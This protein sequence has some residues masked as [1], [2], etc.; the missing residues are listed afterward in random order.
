MSAIKEVYLLGRRGPAQAAFTN[1]EIKELGELAGADVVIDPR[2]A[3]LDPLSRAAL[4]KAPDRATTKK[5]EILQSFA[6]KPPTG[7]PRLLTIRFLVSPV[8]LIGN[9]LFTPYVL[10]YAPKMDRMRHIVAR[11]RQPQDDKLPAIWLAFK[12]ST[13]R[14]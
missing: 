3:E 2:E 13:L 12:H 1:P 5:V 11:L 8:E 7:K 14:L 4:A 10:E 9:A 6:H